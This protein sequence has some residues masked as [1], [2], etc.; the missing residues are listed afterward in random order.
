MKNLEMFS[1][2]LK[3]PRNVQFYVMKPLEMVGFTP[4]KTKKCSVDDAGRQ[5]NYEKLE[6]W[7]V[8]KLESWKAESWK[9]GKLES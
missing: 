9:A 1:F 7:K 4:L 6:S 5:T 3:K 8:G 2:T